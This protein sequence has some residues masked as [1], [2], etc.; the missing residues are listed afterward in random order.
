MD[1]Q[2]FD[3]ELL[4]FDNERI[5]YQLYLGREIAGLTSL[6]VAD[7]L[8]FEEN[9]YLEY[10][11][12]K[13]KFTIELVQKVAHIIKADPK[14]ILST[15]ASSVFREIHDSNILY[16]STF[17]TFTGTSE[18]HNEALLRLIDNVNEANKRLMEVLSQKNKE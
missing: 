2:V 15:P 10:E 7:E 13:R 17:H 11:K 3:S 6:E 18:K 4:T 16:S 14:R 8:G 1:R 5:G 9:E 12:G